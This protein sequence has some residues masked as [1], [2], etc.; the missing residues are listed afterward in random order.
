M[1]DAA[2]FASSPETCG[3]DIAL[4]EEKMAVHSA[5]TKYYSHWFA[6]GEVEKYF[7]AFPDLQLIKKGMSSDGMGLFYTFQSCGKSHSPFK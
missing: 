2:C 3:S 7:S 6:I 1:S 5:K 4:D